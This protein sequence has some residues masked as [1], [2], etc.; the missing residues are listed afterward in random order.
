MRAT[1]GGKTGCR[2]TQN[3]TGGAAAL[4]IEEPS[5]APPVDFCYV[6]VAFRPEAAGWALEKRTFR[7]VK[8]TGSRSPQ[9]GGNPT[10][11]LLGCPC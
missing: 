11:Q 3:P 4:A 9:G 10:A 6:S 5:A 8:L 1:M 7:N 2:S